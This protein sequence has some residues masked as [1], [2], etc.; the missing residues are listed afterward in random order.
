[1]SKE[2]RLAQFTA[3]VVVGLAL[4]VG[5]AIGYAYDAYADVLAELQR[6][7]PQPSK[8]LTGRWTEGGITRQVRWAKP[9]EQSDE[10][11]RQEFEGFVRAARA[12][13]FTE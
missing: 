1:M 11:F 13:K 6:L 7:Q 2:Y 12:T 5:C 9:D 3:L 8:E 4:V 10:E